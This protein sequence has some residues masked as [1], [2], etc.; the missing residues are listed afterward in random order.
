MISNS[1]IAQW[2][3]FGEKYQC[4]L[5]EMLV[6][7]YLSGGLTDGGWEEK[8]HSLKTTSFVGKIDLEYQCL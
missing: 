6:K 7:C 5:I 1:V 3:S 8:V 2:T 4:K